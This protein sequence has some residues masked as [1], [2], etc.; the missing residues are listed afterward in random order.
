MEVLNKLFELVVDKVPNVI[1]QV[2]FAIVTFGFAPY[3]TAVQLARYARRNKV[4]PPLFV[5]IALVLFM[6]AV[7]FTRP[8]FTSG[9]LDLRTMTRTFSQLSNTEEHRTDV[10]FIMLFA[11]G[12]TSLVG[13]SQLCIEALR[14]GRYPQLFRDLHYVATALN[15]PWVVAIYAAVFIAW[16]SIPAVTS[17]AGMLLF[18]HPV[19]FTVFLLSPL[20]LCAIPMLVF[21]LQ[22]DR[23]WYR[24]RPAARWPRR[25]VP[26]YIAAVGILVLTPVY[27]SYL[28]SILYGPESDKLTY[29]IDCFEDKRALYAT[30]VVGNATS[31]TKFLNRFEVVV[32]SNKMTVDQSALFDGLKENI[33]LPPKETRR[34]RLTIASQEAK[35]SESFGPDVCEIADSFYGDGRHELTDAKVQVLR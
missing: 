2:L 29:A 3:R 25:I 15:F 23:R 14:R 31:E 7:G 17:F 18:D 22:M 16:I 24:T 21:G 34:L 28:A 1:A 9:A 33:A 11:L 12:M 19:W 8:F 4:P 20:P 26:I 13:F 10:F 6:V 5:V 30:V 27:L 35:F 32:G